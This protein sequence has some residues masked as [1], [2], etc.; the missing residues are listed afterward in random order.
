MTG[1]TVTRKQVGRVVAKLGGRERSL[2]G[3]PGQPGPPGTRGQHPPTIP[4][5][6]RRRMH[7]VA[8]LLSGDPPRRFTRSDAA[9]HAKR[10]GDPREA[11]PGDPPRP[12][13][14]GLGHEPAGGM[15]PLDVF[16]VR[17]PRGPL[18]VRATRVRTPTVARGG[19]CSDPRQ[20]GAICRPAA[21]RPCSGPGSIRRPPPGPRGLFRRLS[22]PK[23]PGGAR[24]PGIR[25]VRDPH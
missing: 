4:S 1:I 20:P 7:A 19:V 3:V 24:T 2:P 8:A 11:P 9:I 17:E 21:C 13:S 18:R 15:P 12:E 5:C 25:V 10:R 23:R 22:V 6:D 14:L 16:L